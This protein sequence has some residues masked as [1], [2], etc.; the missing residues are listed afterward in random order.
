MIAGTTAHNLSTGSIGGST[1]VVAQVNTVNSGWWFEPYS[2][3]ITRGP[4][5]R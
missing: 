4:G 1:R 3:S 5:S 2:N